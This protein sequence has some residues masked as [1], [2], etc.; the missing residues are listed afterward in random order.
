[1]LLLAAMLLGGCAERRYRTPDDV[2]KIGLLELVD[3]QQARIEV[4]EWEVAQLWRVSDVER[5]D[6]LERRIAELWE[7]HQQQRI[8]TL[9]WEMAKLQEQ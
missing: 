2:T 3:Q 7:W 4:L 6:V 5:I 8:E 1:M 9:E